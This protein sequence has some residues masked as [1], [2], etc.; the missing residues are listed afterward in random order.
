MLFGKPKGASGDGDEM[1][2][3]GPSPEFKD[4]CRTALDEKESFATRCEALYE[5]IQEASGGSAP[6]SSP[7]PMMGA[8]EAGA[9]EY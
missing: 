7:E 3:G 4:L 8:G 1:D 9:E 2:S 6:T 5:L